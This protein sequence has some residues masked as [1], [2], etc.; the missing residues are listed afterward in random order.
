MRRASGSPSDTYV[1]EESRSGL[2]RSEALGASRWLNARDRLP[3]AGKGRQTIGTD[4]KV[5][6]MRRAMH[7]RRE[8]ALSGLRLRGVRL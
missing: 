8:P 6:R 4:L 1:S 2:E 7:A 3:Y 5:I